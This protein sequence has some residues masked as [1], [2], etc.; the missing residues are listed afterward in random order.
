MQNM[1]ISY[2]TVLAPKVHVLKFIVSYS[3]NKVYILHFKLPGIKIWP[4]DTF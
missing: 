3:Q 1:G 4:Y 2:K